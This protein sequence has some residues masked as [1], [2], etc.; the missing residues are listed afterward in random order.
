M[1]I[2]FKKGAA[3]TLIAMAA[4]S[5]FYILPEAKQNKQEIKKTVVFNDTVSCVVLS[6]HDGDTF[7]ALVNDT[8]KINV[9]LQ[10][11][12][13]PELKQQ[14][15][16]QSKKALSQYLQHGPIK[17]VVDKKG[18]DKYGRVIAEVYG[19]DGPINILMVRSGMAFV[20]WE[21]C[22]STK[23]YEPE[24]FATFS[25]LGVYSINMVRPWDY[26]KSL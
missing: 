24:Q 4:A 3:I 14:F 23:Y 17:L 5:G 9:R 22:S 13:A 16:L 21:Y 15:G 1:K 7:R 26:R 25:K 10:C 2:S 12:D 11:I 20:Y 6:V 8:M 19:S 18:L